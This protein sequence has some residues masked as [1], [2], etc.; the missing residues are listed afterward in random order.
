[1]RLR[2]VPRSLSSFMR[3]APW[4]LWVLAGCVVFGA[5]APTASAAKKKARPAKAAARKAGGGSAGVCPMVRLPGSYGL[6]DDVDLIGRSAKYWAVNGPTMVGMGPLN[7]AALVWSDVEQM[8]LLR[9]AVAK[10]EGRMSEAAVLMAKAHL[11]HSLH[12]DPVPLTF[13]ADASTGS[14]GSGGM[15]PGGSPGAMMAPS[16]GSGGM[17]AQVSTSPWFSDAEL[18]KM[19]ALSLKARKARNDAK[20]QGAN[21]MGMM[22]SGSPGMGSGAPMGSGRPPGP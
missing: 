6:E 3:R 20:K 2:V 8:F 7:L 16:S 10:S 22:G 5:S 9:A 1:M 19:M 4:L 13:Q 18:D 14:G 21:G 11:A 15:P 17:Q 12:K